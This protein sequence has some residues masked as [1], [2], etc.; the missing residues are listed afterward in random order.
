MDILSQQDCITTRTQM[1]HEAAQTSITRVK[2]STGIRLTKRFQLEQESLQ[3]EPGALSVGAGTGMRVSLALEELPALINELGPEEALLLGVPRYEVSHYA[4]GNWFRLTTKGSGSHSP[5]KGVLARTKDDFAFPAAG[6]ALVLI[7]IDI[8]SAPSFVMAELDAHGDVWSLLCTAMPELTGLAH[9]YRASTSAGIRD[10]AGNTLSSSR[11]AHIYVLVEDA[12]CAK[13]FLERLQAKLWIANL[14]WIK[15]SKSGSLLVR[16]PV[17]VAVGSPERLIFEAAPHLGDGLWQDPAPREPRYVP[18]A[19]TWLPRAHC[20]ATPK[21]MARFQELVATMKDLERPAAETMRLDYIDTQ[22]DKIARE[23]DI[24][25]ETARQ[26][27][28]ARADSRLLSTDI[29]EFQDPALGRVVVRS[30]LEEPERYHQAYCADPIEPE[31]GLSRARTHFD[32]AGRPHIHSFLHGGFNY[33]LIWD[34]DD[35][36]SRVAEL[37]RNA[38]EFYRRQLP[39]LQLAE[40]QKLELRKKVAKSSGISMA[41]IR[42]IDREVG[43]IPA[44]EEFAADEPCDSVEH[45]PRHPLPCPVKGMEL[46]ST[47]NQ[48]ADIAS[49]RS[50]SQPYDVI[51]RGR[52]GNVVQLLLGQVIGQKNVTTIRPLENRHGVAN[53]LEKF[54]R[55]T[56]KAGSEGKRAIPELADAIL[57]DLT[58]PFPNLAAVAHSP[59]VLPDGSVVAETGY[60]AKNGMFFA[61]DD[62][63]RA[64]AQ[65]VVAK[66]IAD[67]DIRAA[68]AFLAESL[69]AEIPFE[70]PADAATAVSLLLTLLQRPQI[71]IVPMYLITS[72]E[73]QVGKTTLAQIVSLTAFGQPACIDGY[74]TTDEELS[75]RIDAFAF[76]GRN[77][78]VLDN[79]KR[80][81]LIRSQVLERTI[82]AETSS[83][84]I[85]GSTSTFSRSNGMTFVATGNSVRVDGDLA[86]RCLSIRLEA[87]PTRRSE[88]YYSRPDIRQSVLA[89]RQKAIA[90]ALTIL[91]GWAQSRE[92]AGSGGIRF[93]DWFRTVGAAIEHATRLYDINSPVKF[94][95]L[96]EESVS[97]SEEDIA[98]RDLFSFIYSIVGDD[99]FRAATLINSPAANLLDDFGDETV[100]LRLGQM[101]PALGGDPKASGVSAKALGEALDRFKGAT[102]AI[103]TN[104]GRQLM[105][106]QKLR[107]GVGGGRG[108]I[109]RLQIE[110]ALA[111]APACSVNGESCSCLQIERA[112]LA[113]MLD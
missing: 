22:T 17:D 101:L 112:R 97:A 34:Y 29:V 40:Y 95:S 41:A 93:P 21:E 69:F 47:I 92:V 106:L 100:M 31:E 55:F 37:G 38:P 13:P 96:L 90:A 111:P 99:E 4:T 85:L 82:T 102:S 58:A 104:N 33:R 53:Q 72:S 62:D 74:P 113:K 14:G 28:T 59:I 39:N 86:T 6:P 18:G 30:I 1:P 32:R 73:A 15:T 81:T 98:L 9:V 107:S 36:A 61:L 88:R 27:V 35:L 64:A 43:K 66:P 25:P 70:R 80:A 89:Q 54:V 8:K 105:R 110:Q 78:V 76:E 71:P 65:E 42:V 11:N 5:G 49:L 75:K 56:G 60:N 83:G 16:S 57:N 2:A 12:A 52:G 23:H 10:A 67:K 26:L 19:L 108:A 24:D 63:L 44:F 46:S 87:P 20:L 50:Q 45:D 103:C 3:V 91:A 51:F 77:L 79:I 48:I 7:D 84:R 94:S 68:Y 109:W